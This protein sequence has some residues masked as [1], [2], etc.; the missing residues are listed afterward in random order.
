MLKTQQR[1]LDRGSKE[2][3]VLKQSIEELKQAKIKIPE[4]F[5]KRKEEQYE[6]P[7]SRFASLTTSIRYYEVLYGVELVLHISSNDETLNDIENHIQDLKAIGRSEDFVHVEEIKRVH[8]QDPN[9]KQSLLAAYIDVERLKAKDVFL[10]EYGRKTN[11]IPVRGTKYFLNKDYKIVGRKRVFN[12]KWVVY[13]S[14]YFVDAE[15]KHVYL[16][17]DGYIVNLL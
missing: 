13:V 15:S 12:K 7:Y 8:L 14:G 4:E 9:E 16:D 6:I 17:D 2:Y 10:D 5:K 1:D 3:L 11:A